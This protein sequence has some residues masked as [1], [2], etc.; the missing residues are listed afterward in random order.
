VTVPM[1]GELRAGLL[2]RP[3]R[4]AGISREEL[5]QEL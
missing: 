5:L 2:R 3:M 1:H 4:E